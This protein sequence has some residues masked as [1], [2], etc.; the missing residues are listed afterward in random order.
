[1]LVVTLP[2]NITDINDEWPL[3]K[4]LIDDVGFALYGLDQE[5]KRKR[6][7]AR[8]KVLFE[9]SSDGILIADIETRQM[10]YANPAICRL[11]GYTA[12]EFE[13]LQIADL[14]PEQEL[15]EII[16]GFEAQAAA[17]LH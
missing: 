15:P 4:E 7:E 12:S 13:S 16:S 8:Y 11:F 3:F 5:E 1:M 2:E 17:T 9:S 14:H 10:R 6:A